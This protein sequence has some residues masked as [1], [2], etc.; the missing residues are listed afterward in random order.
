MQSGDYLSWQVDHPFSHKKTN[1]FCLE[2]ALEI[3]KLPLIAV[4]RCL[5]GRVVLDTFEVRKRL[6]VASE[7]I[8]VQT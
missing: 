1:I 4:F 3:L 8:P 7:C 6:L 2:N 5:G